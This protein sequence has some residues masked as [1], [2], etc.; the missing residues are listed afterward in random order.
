MKKILIVFSAF[1]ILVTISFSQNAPAK[2]LRIPKEKNKILN[3][4]PE[5]KSVTRGTGIYEADINSEKMDL[6]NL[7]PF[8][9]SLVAGFG[10]DDAI[11]ASNN[12]GA[13]RDGYPVWDCRDIYLSF[14]VINNGAASVLSKFYIKIYVDGYETYT[15]YYDKELPVNNFVYWRDINIGKYWSGEHRLT[16]MADVTNT[17]AESNETDNNYTRYK[18]VFRDSLPPEIIHTPPTG[19]TLNQPVTISATAVDYET[20]VTDFYLKYRVSGDYWDNSLYVNFN[21]GS[22]QIPA[23]YVTDK[24]VDYKI[25]ARDEDWNEQ[26]YYSASD[27]N[28]DYYS[29]PVTIPAS[30]VVPK[31]ITGGSSFTS[32]KLFSLPYHFGTILANEIFSEAGEYKKAWRFQSLVGTG[33]FTDAETYQV[34]K[35][36]SYF[37]IT[38]NDFSIV[39]KIT[40]K[41]NRLNYYDYV[42]VPVKAGWNLIGNPLPFRVSTAKLRVINPVNYDLSK[43]PDAYEYTGSGG[44][45]KADYLNPWEGLAIYSDFDTKLQFWVGYTNIGKQSAKY[46]NDSYDWIAKVTAENGES[47][48]M[49]NFFGVQENAQSGKDTYDSPEP[50][51]IP[52]AVSVFFPHPEWNERVVNFSEDI[53]SQNE[54]ENEWNMVLR[55]GSTKAITLKIEGLEN[56]PGSLN[57]YLYDT[58]AN[59]IYNLTDRAMIQIPGFIGEKKYKILIGSKEFI[60]SKS[61]TEI[62][63]AKI[64]LYQNYPN[65]FNPSTNIRF[66]IPNDA[67][68][69]IILYDIYGRKVNTL[70]DDER[71]SGYHD[72]MVSGDELASGIYYYQFI[73]SG[74]SNYNEIKKM[75]LIK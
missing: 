60:G 73:V 59:L 13:N 29:I 27:E 30:S 17:V 2:R 26:Y 11:L 40:L 75:V 38:K 24:G 19:A 68:V 10:W 54:T 70:L 22:A 41:T 5:Q 33:S 23:A 48:D 45:L 74:V 42:G 65:P 50:P 34:E 46:I 62:M 18:M 61:N 53:R 32:Y 72:I 52:E 4:A 21:Q 14:A 36:K 49:E 66:A 64:A 7:R 3:S 57:K 67:H 47:A 15:D 58:D 43:M 16:I 20:S 1:C 51:I 39:P 8:M 35:G 28:S 55:S 44:W 71:K 6:P 25:V 12:K 37:L 69:K 9:P 31:K 63:P 56:L